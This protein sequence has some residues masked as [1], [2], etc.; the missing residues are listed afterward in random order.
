MQ[1]NTINVYT[2]WL[3]TAT[4][5]EVAFVDAVFALCEKHYEEG[6]DTVVETF[7]PKEILTEFK[8]IKEVREH[9]GLQLEA[10]SNARWGEDSDSEVE[11]L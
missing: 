10:A 1:S 8:S 9:C 6:G 2:S 11:A 4:E 3:A 5:E 7:H